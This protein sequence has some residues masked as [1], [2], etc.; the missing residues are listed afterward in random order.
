MFN[1]NGSAPF[2]NGIMISGIFTVN[3]PEMAPGE[4]FEIFD[5]NGSRKGTLRI[6]AFLGAQFT[7]SKTNPPYKISVAYDGNYN[8]LLGCTLKAIG[9]Q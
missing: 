4:I 5:A 7:R 1:I 9:K 3:S 6:V 2:K 8:D